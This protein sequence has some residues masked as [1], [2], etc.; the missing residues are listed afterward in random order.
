MNQSGLGDT[1]CPVTHLSG[2]SWR[3]AWMGVAGRMAWGNLVGDGRLVLGP[4]CGSVRAALPNRAGTWRHLCPIPV[5]VAQDETSHWTWVADSA[6]SAFATAG[7]LLWVEL[8]GYQRCHEKILRL[9]RQQPPDEATEAVPGTW[10]VT[11]QDLQMERFPTEVN[12]R[13]LSLH[14][15]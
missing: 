5:V 9:V 11:T 1:A 10:Y 8:L 15:Y 2:H 6:L 14:K 3:M 12:D 4:S 13:V 7:S